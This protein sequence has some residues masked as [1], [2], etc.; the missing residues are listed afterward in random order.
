[1]WLAS[2]PPQKYSEDILD[3]LL[4][5][6]PFVSVG[7]HGEF[8]ANLGGLIRYWKLDALRAAKPGEELPTEAQNFLRELRVLEERFGLRFLIAPTAPWACWLCAHAPEATK[9]FLSREE[10][11]SRFANASLASIETFLP[12]ILERAEGRAAL[13]DFR[14]RASELGW[15]TLGGLYAAIRESAA[16]DG[17]LARFGSVFEKLLR[18]LQGA[19]DFRLRAHEPPPSFERTIHLARETGAA[20]DPLVLVNDTLLAWE[21]RL[22]A[23]RSLLKGVEVSFRGERRRR[24]MVFRLMLPKPSRDVALLRKLVEE[25]W[26][27]LSDPSSLSDG[28]GAFSDEIDIIRLRSLGFDVE[29]DRQLSLFNP[30]REENLESW[31]LLVARLLSRASPGKPLQVGSWRPFESWLP[32]NSVEWVDWGQ[33]ES[34]PVVRDHPARPSVAFANPIPLKSFDP[35]APTLKS[36]ED[37][38]DWLEACGALGTLERVREENEER[39]YARIEHEKGSQF[40]VYWNHAR[41]EALVHG[42]FEE[43]LQTQLSAPTE[44][45]GAYPCSLVTGV[46]AFS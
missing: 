17:L 12:D 2:P 15:R 7:P 16:R 39:S 9:L 19:D 26:Q 22:R 11:E 44:R 4:G 24:T 23:R 43:A 1:M 3:L 40:W 38:L 5:L 37:F 21:A 13:H 31:N 46:S 42:T 28:G 8:L 30:G 32:E 36:E 18:R 29:S 45:G 14:E 41:R 10:I 33:A 6:S 35:K 25:K 27:S 20:D 34:L